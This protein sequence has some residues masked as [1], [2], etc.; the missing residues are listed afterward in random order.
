MK[1]T[2]KHYELFKS[3]CSRWIDKLGILDY[4]VCYYHEDWSDSYGEARAWC[5]W[6]IEGRIASMCLNTNWKRDEVTISN[7]KRSAFHEVSHLLLGRL[8]T[9][10]SARFVMPED[11]KE[12]IHAVIRRLEN[13]V[14]ERGKK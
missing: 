8:D 5:R 4:R 11:L 13:L 10:A 3:E 1:T 6:N 14:F 7:I 9:L 2:K 12:E